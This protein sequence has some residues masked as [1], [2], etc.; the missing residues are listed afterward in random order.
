MNEGKAKVKELATGE[1]TTV[2]LNEIATYI[3]GK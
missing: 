1:Q 2:P 3:G